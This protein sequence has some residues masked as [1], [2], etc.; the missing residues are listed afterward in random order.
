MNLLQVYVEKVHPLH[1]FYREVEKNGILIDEEERLRQLK[2]ETLRIRTLQNELNTLLREEG[3]HLEPN[4]DFNVNSNAKQVPLTLYSPRE[5]GG[6]GI[7]PRK[8]C[9]EDTLAAIVNNEKKIANQPRVK[10]I[11]LLTIEVRKAR[12]NKNT[13]IEAERSDDGRIRTQ[14]K[15]TGTETYRTST[16]ILKPPMSIEKEGVALQTLTKHGQNVGGVIT[17]NNLRKFYVADPGFVFIEPDLSQAEARHVA[18]LSKNWQLLKD[19]DKKEFIEVNGK[20]VKIDC[21]RRLAS[22]IY[23]KEPQFIN[24]DPERQVGK[25]ARHGANYDMGK[26]EFMIQLA[27]HNVFVSEWKCGKILDAVHAED[28]SI[29]SIFHAEIQEMLV[30]KDLVLQTPFGR[31]RR[32]FNKW[33]RDLWKEAYAFIPQSVVSDQTKFAAVRISKRLPFAKFLSESHDS[34]LAMVPNTDK[35]IYW[36]TKIAKEEL[37]TPVN[38][39]HCTLSRDYDL[40][41]PC[42]FQIGK[43]WKEF[44]E[45]KNPNGMRKLNL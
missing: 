36:F 20:K 19:F 23:S 34:F 11:I 3:V 43:N 44:D 29:R 41:I 8:D 35:A 45:E 38:Y 6:L 2:A 30:A 31:I 10:R 7:P 27:G 26:H 37:E 5:K 4:E 1:D 42:E 25:F 21:H 14:F 32:F 17:E 13:Y 28:P 15:I 22:A 16:S 33:G 18:V 9:G 40:V 12:K 24:D 39:R